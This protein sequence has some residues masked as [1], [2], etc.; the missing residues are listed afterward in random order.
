MSKIL[1]KPFSWANKIYRAVFRGSPNLITTSDLNRQFEALKKELYQHQQA[2]NIVV[3][4]MDVTWSGKNSIKVTGS[5]V[6]CSGVRFDIDLTGAYTFSAENQ[7]PVKYEL[8]LYAKK[9]L[10]TSDDDFTKN[11]SGAKFE[12]GTTQKAADHYVYGEAKVIFAKADTPDSEFD[13]AKNNDYEY[14]CTLLKG[15]G[16][17]TIYVALDSRERNAYFQKCT[18]PMGGDPREPAQQYGRFDSFTVSGASNS[19]GKLV[20]NSGDDWREIAHKLWSRIYTLEKR[21]FM[22]GQY[23]VNYITVESGQAEDGSSYTRENPSSIRQFSKEYSNSS[24]TGKSTL[25]YSFYMSGAIC[26]IAGNAV[27]EKND[28]VNPES[29]QLSFQVGNDKNEIPP[30]VYFPD[31]AA[32]LI[33][34]PY[35]DLSATPTIRGC[36][37]ENKIVFIGVPKTGIKLHFYGVYLCKTVPFWHVSE[38]DKYGYLNDIR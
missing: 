25:T 1:D 19:G 7:T 37:D 13:Y 38:D 27:I 28:N 16:V 14:V 18:V 35:E 11:I 4:D 23:G 26:F 3:S 8:R 2:F 29:I 33:I 5:Y 31:V 34:Q 6:F 15:V 30:G 9:T 20:P 36:I 21:L 17:S 10:V 12:D 24:S 22:E 32:A